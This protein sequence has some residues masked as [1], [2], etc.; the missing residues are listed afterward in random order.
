MKCQNC[1]SKQVQGSDYTYY[2][3]EKQERAYKI[4][5]S[6]TAW[7][8]DGCTSSWLQGKSKLTKE[9]AGEQLAFLAE[10]KS[11]TLKSEYDR[12]E[13]FW[14]LP[15]GLNPIAAFAQR[16]PKYSVFLCGADVKNSIDKNEQPPNNFFWLIQGGANSSPEKSDIKIPDNPEDII[17]TVE[18]MNIARDG[19]IAIFMLDTIK[20]NKFNKLN[21]GQRYYVWFL[22][23]NAY[24]MQGDDKQ[25]LYCFTESLKHDNNE[26]AMAHRKIA[27]LTKKG[28]QLDNENKK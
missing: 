14:Y 27:E 21:P 10:F 25:A 1:D 6:K 11:G 18:K 28:I 19:D 7:I 5:G 4:Q 23:G 20:G 3:G 9:M 24:L 26:N 16:S 17:S 22:R 2:Y 15:V 12:N 13:G 8:C